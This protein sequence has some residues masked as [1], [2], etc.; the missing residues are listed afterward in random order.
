M[1]LRSLLTPS[2]YRWDFIEICDMTTQFRRLDIEV[3]DRRFPFPSKRDP[4]FM[5][6]SIN[7]ERYHMAISA[8]ERAFFERLGIRVAEL[9]RTQNI[10]SILM[11]RGQRAILD[12]ELAAIRRRHQSAEPSRQTQRRALPGR[13]RVPTYSDRDRKSIA[14]PDFRRSP[15][16]NTAPSWP[17]PSSTAFAPWR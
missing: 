15:S 17:P 12:A 14:T 16:P 11:L 5:S 9:R 13:L 4:R 7:L 2:F 1:P 6:L 3:G 10:R 8:N